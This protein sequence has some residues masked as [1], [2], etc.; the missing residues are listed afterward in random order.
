MRQKLVKYQHPKWSTYRKP[1]ELSLSELLRWASA[2]VGSNIEGL[3]Y[4]AACQNELRRRGA[5]IHW[6][7]EYGVHAPSRPMYRKATANSLPARD[8]KGRFVSRR[9]ASANKRRRARY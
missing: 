3:D 9:R 2:N 8:S 1:Q 6:T 4:K 5:G 7:E